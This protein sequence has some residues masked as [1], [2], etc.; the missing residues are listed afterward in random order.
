MSHTKYA[1]HCMYLLETRSNS[2]TNVNENRTNVVL[3][4]FAHNA[5]ESVHTLQR[6]LILDVVLVVHARHHRRQNRRAELGH[7]NRD[8]DRERD[9]DRETETEKRRQK[10]QR[11]RKRKKN[12]REKRSDRKR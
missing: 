7:L 11:Q 3:A 1:I 6:N 2:Q 10:R 12:D 9:E 4:Q 5:T 8:R